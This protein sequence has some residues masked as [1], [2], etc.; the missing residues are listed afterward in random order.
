M[1]AVRLVAAKMMVAFGKSTPLALSVKTLFQVNVGSL[2]GPC[3]APRHAMGHRSAISTDLAPP[4]RARYCLGGSV[5]HQ[6]ASE[7]RPIR[8]CDVG[9]PPAP[10]SMDENASDVKHMLGAAF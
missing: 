5:T 6:S 1:Y 4:P 9:Q 3:R 10:P 8:N 2:R 7:T